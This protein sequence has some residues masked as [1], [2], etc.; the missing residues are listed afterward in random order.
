M[1]RKTLLLI[2]VGIATI[3]F[4]NPVRLYEE[5]K[6]ANIVRRLQNDLPYCTFE[7]A[8][9]VSN[10]PDSWITYKTKEGLSFAYPPDLTLD[11]Q[12]LVIHTSDYSS[13]ME[14]NFE[15][16]TPVEGDKENYLSQKQTL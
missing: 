1:S 13:I 2:L 12:S 5:R 3:V 11:N 14:I 9:T 10:V 4:I 6:A 15:P 8:N 7:S 16:I